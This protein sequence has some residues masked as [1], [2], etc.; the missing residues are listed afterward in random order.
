M[1]HVT[2]RH[3][4]GEKDGNV[5]LLHNGSDTTQP[6]K[7]PVESPEPMDCGEMTDS[8]PF[9]ADNESAAVMDVDE[10]S[11]SAAA[12]SNG[13]SLSDAGTM[14]PPPLDEVDAPNQINATSKAQESSQAPGSCSLSSPSDTVTPSPL[15]EGASKDQESNQTPRPCSPDLL[16][17]TGTPSP[18]DEMDAPTPANEREEGSKNQESCQTQRS[19]APGS[20]DQGSSVSYID[21]KTMTEASKSYAEQSVDSSRDEQPSTELV[22]NGKGSVSPP[23]DDISALTDKIPAPSSNSTQGFPIESASINKE[24]AEPSSEELNKN[25]QLASEKN[26]G[27]NSILLPTTI[28]TAKN[29]KDSTSGNIILTLRN[30]STTMT[31][32]SLLNTTLAST[33]SAGNFSKNSVKL[34]T[35]VNNS[36]VLS[37]SSVTITNSEASVT[38]ASSGASVTATGSGADLNDAS[39]RQPSIKQL[40][41]SA[42]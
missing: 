37:S 31:G 14:T 38:A 32:T 10:S 34:T 33:S 8:L 20:L 39:M 21:S 41:D 1:T 2:S 5:V 40:L 7:K 3:I 30:P 29:D 25:R 12:S 16:P 26:T 11:Q 35:S 6:S 27:M 22:C 9:A 4:S 15:G 36:G 17:D 23:N 19:S 24:S 28:E 13:T 42:R 18:P